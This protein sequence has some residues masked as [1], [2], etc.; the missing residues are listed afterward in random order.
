MKRALAAAA[1]VLATLAF[2]GGAEAQLP[3]PLSLEARGGVAVPV[4]DF[5]DRADDAFGFGFSAHFQVAPRVS[6]Y[7]GY[8]QVDFDMDDVGAEGTDSGWEAGARL[9]FAGV[10]YSPWIRAGL[11]FHD[12]EMETAN[13]EFDGEDEV[14]FEVGAG[15]A[16]P[17]GQRVAVSPGIAYRRYSTEFF[18]LGD[19][20][21]SYLM[22]DIGLR[23]RL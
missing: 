22:L 23:M 12:F 21:V 3:V 10:G 6:L 9:A 14:G 18:D 11:L 8:S 16:F 20:D 7:G 17:L 5:A 13:A 4:G 19:Q 15:A 2:A 1:A